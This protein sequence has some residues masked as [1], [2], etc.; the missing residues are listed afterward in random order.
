MKQLNVLKIPYG[1]SDFDIIRQGGYYYVDKTMYL[2]L[3]EDTAS[4]L[5][6]I[7]PRR[8]GKTLFVNMMKSYYDLALKDKFEVLFGSTWIGQHPTPLA[9]TF[10]ILHFDFSL[11]SGLGKDLEKSFN[12]Y[13]GSAIDA[14]I[15]KYSE[16]YPQYI[17][18]WVL[19]AEKAGEKLNILGPA[20]KAAGLPLYLIIDEYDNFTNVVLAKEGKEA[21]S[22]LLHANGFYRDI[23][24]IF[25]ASFRRIFLIGV[26]PITLDDITSGYNIDWG[27]SQDPRFNSMLGFNQ[28]DVRRMLSYYHEKGL[29]QS[30]IEA[31][32]N[33]M[34][35]WYDNY[36]FCEEC[37]GKERV[38]NCDMVLYYLNSL[39]TT[40][41]APKNMVDKNIRTDYSKLRQL[42]DIDCGRYS[43]ER[44]G[45]LQKI[46]NDHEIVFPLKSSFPAMEIGEEENFLSLVYYYG[47]LSIGGEDMGMPCMVIPNRCVQEQYWSFMRSFYDNACKINLMEI[48]MSLRKMALDGNWLPFVELISKS[49]Q[50][51][52]AIRDAI[53][54]EH[55]LQG[56]FKAYLALSDFYLIWS[57]AELNKGYADFLLLPNIGEYPQITH[58]YLIELKFV[59]P[60]GPE[61][62]IKKKHDDAYAQLMKY[63]NDPRLISL[64][65]GT[66]LHRLIII[67]H[68]PTLIPP[69]EI[70]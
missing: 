51:N 66:T 48:S 44:F 39:L 52:Y 45:L 42:V 12:N 7:R 56:F 15:K 10:Q 69:E 50:A 60:E 8:F 58:S 53:Q 57:E 36:C 23:F 6:L 64:A 4:Y 46:C 54:G 22:T 13:C 68:G 28:E 11:V 37:Y 35:P 25:K 3:M 49:Y 18:E 55:N 67:F 40:G 62:E 63:A 31:M 47:M 33:E 9:N 34:K 2:P 43:Q 5:F 26:S 38:F 65:Q 59:K 24:K 21:F 32:L 19:K 70:N 14:F 27:I 41:K 29:I 17:V 61:M 16:F 1:I 30:D 20:A